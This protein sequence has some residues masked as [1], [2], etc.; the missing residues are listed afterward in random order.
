MAPHHPHPW[1]ELRHLVD[2]VVHWRSDMPAGKA[3]VTDGRDIWLADDLSQAERRS[4]LMHELVHLRRGHGSCQPPEVEGSVRRETA[5]RLIPNVRRLADA[6]AWA[7]GH[8]GEA[9]EELWVI[10]EVLE[11]RL[12]WLHPAERAFVAARLEDVRAWA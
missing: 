4:V 9:A 6:M 10:E 5:R 1:R 12:R 3:G 11:D 8:L 7:G 2:V